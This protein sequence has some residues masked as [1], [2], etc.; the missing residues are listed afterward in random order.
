M[1]VARCRREFGQD[2]GVGGVEVLDDHESQAAP[3]GYVGEKAFQGF[4]AA[5]RSADAD[6]GGRIAAVGG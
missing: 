3:R 6:D 5:G 1:V 2:A 4:E